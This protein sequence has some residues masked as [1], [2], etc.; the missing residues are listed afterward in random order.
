MNKLILLVLIMLLLLSVGCAIPQGATTAI[1]AAYDGNQAVK[2]A[3]NLYQK[4]AIRSLGESRDFQIKLVKNIYENQAKKGKVDLTTVIQGL[5]KL[6]KNL[7]IIDG[8][9][10]SLVKLYD[11]TM[12]TLLYSD[13]ALNMA[14]D[15]VVR[16]NMNAAKLRELID[17]FQEQQFGVKE[18]P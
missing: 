18:T 9:K 15:L 16:S 14:N 7:N 4:A 6:L 10:D 11:K 13:E 3:V 1:G 17:K 5:E 12:Q 8:R 2:Q